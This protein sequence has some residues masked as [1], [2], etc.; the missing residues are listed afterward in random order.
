MPKFR[1]IVQ[2]VVSGCVA[3]RYLGP[4]LSKLSRSGKMPER[5]WR[6]LPVQTS[7]DV[8]LPNGSSFTY[9]STLNDGVGRVL[10]WRGWDGWEP[11][12]C[13]P[14]FE[15]AM[16]SSVVL[17][18]GAN[19]GLYTMLACAANKSAKVLSFE[20]VPRVRDALQSH[21]KINDWQDRCCVVGSAVSNFDGVAPLHVPFRDVPLSASLDESGFRRTDGYVIDIP[22][23]TID[24]TC[25]NDLFVDLVKIDAEGFDDQVLEGMHNVISH[26]LPT[27]IVECNP[28]GPYQNIE[29]ILNRYGYQFFNLQH[30]R[31]THSAHI[32]PLKDSH[33]REN[34][35]CIARKEVIEAIL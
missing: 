23:V 17:D 8:S 20:P 15:L 16:H 33:N 5:I 30:E 10:F 9:L 35:L 11:E 18:I 28:D 26:S 31:P 34:Y 21:V 24:S 1:P 25:G 4:T 6:K 12:T 2:S 3:N 27:I 19:T 29:E 7:F 22:V 32:R 13:R 14:F